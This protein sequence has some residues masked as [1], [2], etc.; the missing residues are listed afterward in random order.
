MK[1]IPQTLHFSNLSIL[2]NQVSKLLQMS[3]LY[4]K[5]NALLTTFDT[6]INGI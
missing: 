5:R 1:S 3:M 6:S 2:V 4:I